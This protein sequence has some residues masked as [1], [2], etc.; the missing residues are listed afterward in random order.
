MKIA[1][2]G[3]FGDGEIFPGP[4]RVARELYFELRRNNFNLI[5][6]QYFFSDFKQSSFLKK[7]FGKQIINDNG[8]RIFGVLPLI[9]FLIKEQFEIIHIINSQRFI[10]FLFLIKPLIKSKIISTLHSFIKNEIPKNNFWSKRY[11]VDLIVEKLIVKK[12]ALLVFPSELLFKTFNEYYKISDKKYHIIPNGVNSLFHHNTKTFT[13]IEDSLKIV[14]YNGFNS[15]IDRRLDEILQ[16]LK[17]VSGK[18]QLFVI[19]IEKKVI[20]SNNVEIY[21][22]NTMSQKELINFLSDKHFVLKSSAFDTFS[23]FVAECMLVGLIPIVNKNIGIT[24]FIFHEHNG[25]IYDITSTESLSKLMNNISEGKYDL[26]QISMNAKNIFEK[27]NWG[28]ISNQYIAAYN[29]VL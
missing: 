15:M 22:K 9:K 28:K 24:E 16:S 6:I 10:F 4:E 23:I 27:L 18:I 20:P 14:F 11:F 12:S 21:F 5:F 17:S 29:S 26:N 3:R 25:F 8:I 7:L 13:K 2:I 1:L 19:G